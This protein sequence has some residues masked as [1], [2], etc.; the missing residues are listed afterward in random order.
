MADL[1]GGGGG[2]WLNPVICLKFTLKAQEM[3]ALTFKILRFSWG[4]MPLDPL[5]LSCLRH[6]QIRTLLC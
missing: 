1:G 5:S 6:S 3:A 4:S 2:G